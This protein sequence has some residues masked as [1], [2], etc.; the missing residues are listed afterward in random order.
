MSWRNLQTTLSMIRQIENLRCESISS[1]TV[2]IYSKDFLNLWSDTTE[3]PGIINLSSYDSKSYDFV[4]LSDYEFAVL[5]KEKN[6]TFCL[7]LYC[8]LFI[9]RVA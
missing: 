7:F 4:V 3:K 6:A 1:K 5:R 2:L 8:L 9:N